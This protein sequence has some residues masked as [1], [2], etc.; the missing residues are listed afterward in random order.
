[1]KLYDTSDEVLLVCQPKTQAITIYL[2]K[3]NELRKYTF[4]DYRTVQMQVI[5]GTLKSVEVQLL[6][7]KDIEEVP[8]YKKCEISSGQAGRLIDAIDL[9]LQDGQINSDYYMGKTAIRVKTRELDWALDCFREAD[10]SI[11]PEVFKS[12]KSGCSVS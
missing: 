10:I 3:G 5:E 11:N 2:Q 6:R 4:T 12:S 8:A 1:M 7:Q 9:S